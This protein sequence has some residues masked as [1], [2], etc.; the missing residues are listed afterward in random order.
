MPSSA[1]IASLNL[2]SVVTPTYLAA[3]DRV[4][5]SHVKGSYLERLFEGGFN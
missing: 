2:D 1:A 5:R 4:L 3:S